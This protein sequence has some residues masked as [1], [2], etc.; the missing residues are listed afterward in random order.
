MS[1]T[2]RKGLVALLLLG[3]AS[4]AHA[5]TPEPPASTEL[6]PA[7]A[8]PKSNRISFESLVGYGGVGFRGG[9]PKFTAS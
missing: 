8:P 4:L 7:P 2:V 6:P 1:H 9:V 3:F 5:Q